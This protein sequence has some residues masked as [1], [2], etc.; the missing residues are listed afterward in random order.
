MSIVDSD[1]TIAKLIST[2]QVIVNAGAKFSSF[3]KG[4]VKLN[5]NPSILLC[6]AWFDF[7][8]RISASEFIQS[9]K[10]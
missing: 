6:S 10:H 4:G 5:K 9:G 8:H 3:R 1:V 7:M 2:N